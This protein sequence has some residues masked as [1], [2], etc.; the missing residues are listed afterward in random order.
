M[1]KVQ[2]VLPDDVLE[3]LPKD[4]QSCVPYLAE[5]LGTVIKSYEESLGRRQPGLLGA[6]L[7][8]YEKTILMDMLI[9]MALGQLRQKLEAKAGSELSPVV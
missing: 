6:P 2:L 5:F 9:D 8:R 1:Y 4:P 3:H 7:S